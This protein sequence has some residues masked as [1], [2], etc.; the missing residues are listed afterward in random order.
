MNKVNIKQSYVVDKPVF[1]SKKYK[2]GHC[3]TVMAIV[4]FIGVCAL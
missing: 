1:A 3:S 2:Y 4:Y